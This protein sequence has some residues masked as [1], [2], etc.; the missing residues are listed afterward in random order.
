MIPFIFSIGKH[1]RVLFN[2]FQQETQPGLVACKDAAKRLIELGMVFTP[3]EEAIR[4]SVASMK[5][6]GFLRQSNM[7]S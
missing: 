1:F 7:Q 4:E 3:I 6:K 2:R 5:E